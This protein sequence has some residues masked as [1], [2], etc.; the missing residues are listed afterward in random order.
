MKKR[1]LRA[2]LLP[3]FLLFSLSLSWS[4]TPD[5]SL[6]AGPGGGCPAPAPTNLVVL[7]MTPNTAY[8]TWLSSVGGLF[9][10]IDI[11][12]ITASVF[13]P[14]SYSPTESAMV[15]GLSP[16]HCYRFWVSASYCG[17]YGFGA[18]SAPAEGCNGYIIID[19]LAEFPAPG[20]PPSTPPSLQN[21]TTVSLC[22]QRSAANG[23]YYNNAGELRLNYSQHNT[24]VGIAL[25]AESNDLRANLK[26]YNNESNSNFRLYYYP[27]PLTLSTT[28]VVKY[29]DNPK[30]LNP[31]YTTVLQCDYALISLPTAPQAVAQVNATIVNSTYLGALEYWS[32]GT[33]PNTY[34]VRPKGDGSRPA[35]HASRRPGAAQE[36]SPFLS[37]PSPNPFSTVALYD[38]VVPETGPVRISLFDATGR[39]AQT[40]WDTCNQEAGQY[41]V[42]VSGAGLPDGVYF[43]RVQVNGELEVFRLVKQAEQ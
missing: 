8:L 15:S 6:P 18:Q 12:D 1:F 28:I 19:D 11:Y 34:L 14:S 32:T 40:I 10:K 7:Q 38:Y 3:L 37:V 4:A 25:P 33:C 16:A 30:A 2:G 22:I 29:T 17:F 35:A 23:N 41:E 13:L 9:Y 21:G 31:T 5:E 20:T 36:A 43:L 26:K 42:Q 39:L 24:L 27:N